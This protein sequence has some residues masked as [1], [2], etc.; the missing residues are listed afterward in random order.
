M[1]MSENFNDSRSAI[2]RTVNVVMDKRGLF[3]LFSLL[4]KMF[5]NFWNINKNKSW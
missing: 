4:L 5:E 3:L 1:K 2:T